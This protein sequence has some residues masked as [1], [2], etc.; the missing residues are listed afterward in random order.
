[1]SENEN[2][3]RCCQQNM[4]VQGLYYLAVV[5][6]TK[7]LFYMNGNLLQI[8]TKKIIYKSDNVS[9]VLPADAAVFSIVCQYASHLSH[10]LA[11]IE[12]YLSDLLNY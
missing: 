12:R 10:I 2:W 8:E 4:V 5:H 6:L 9:N 11:I 1:M 3:K 7:Q